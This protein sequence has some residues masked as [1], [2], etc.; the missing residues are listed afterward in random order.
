MVNLRWTIFWSD[1]SLQ[2]VLLTFPNKSALLTLSHLVTR[3]ILEIKQYYC[4]QWTGKSVYIW[5]GKYV[6]QSH[7][8]C[9]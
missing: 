9:Q 7:T 6:V 8:T 4:A 1:A 5:G 2:Q 3:T